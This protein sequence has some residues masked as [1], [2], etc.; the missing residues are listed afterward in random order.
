MILSNTLYLFSNVTFLKFHL[1]CLLLALQEL[2]LPET[3]TELS[4]LKELPNRPV[5][6]PIQPL[7]HP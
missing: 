3:P 4:S 5:A 6:V 1:C 2:L 7:S